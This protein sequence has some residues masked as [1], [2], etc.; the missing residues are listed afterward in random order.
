M[1]GKVDMAARRQVTNKLRTQYRKASKAGKGEILD[2]VGGH[3]GDGPFDGRRMLTGPRL[4]DAA[5]QVDGR[6]L[7]PRGF[8][9]A[10]ALL[11]HV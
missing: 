10:R 7:R 1:E 9:D 8:S 2:R 6:R 4:P 5:E 3:H 11:E